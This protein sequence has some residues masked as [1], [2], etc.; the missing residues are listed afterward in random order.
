MRKLLITTA[1]VA[2]LL[3]MPGAAMADPVITPIFTAVGFSAATSVALAN[4]TGSILLS[5]AAQALQGRPSRP[6]LIRELQMPSSIPPHRFVYGRARVPGTW[7]PGWVVDGDIFYGCLIL[8]SRPSEGNATIFLDKREV[9]LTGD[10]YDLASDGAT[11]TNAPFA[12]HCR[13]WM[14][15]GDQ[16]GPPDK[17]IQGGDF[18][19][20]MGDPTGEDE[21]KFWPTDAWQG[22]T[23]LWVR[24]WAGDNKTRQSRWPRTPPQVEVL[25]D[26]SRVWDPRDAAQDP[27]DPDT[28]G[29]DNNQALCLLDALM[30]NP[31][32]RRRLKHVMRETWEHAADVADED[33]PLQAGGTEKRYTTNG[34][35]IWNGEREIEDQVSPLVAAGGGNLISAGGSLGYAS[36][37]YRAPIY[38]VSDVLSGQPFRFERLKPG[39]DLPRAIRAEYISPARDWQSAELQPYAVPGGEAPDG[40]D[41]G[42]ERLPL[43]TV[44]SATQ[45]MRLQ[46]MRAMKAGAQR[47]LTCELPPSAF[48]LLAGA[49]VHVYLPNGSDPRNG[50]YEITTL[51]PASWLESEDGVAM[52]IPVEMRENSEAIYAWES[53]EEQEIITPGFTPIDLQ[54]QPPQS[55]VATTGQ[56]GAFPDGRPG[57]QVDFTASPS[58]GIEDYAWHWRV[59]GGAWQMGGRLDADAD[60]RFRLEVD[61]DTDYDFR[62]RSIRGDQASAWVELADVTA[63]PPDLDLDPPHSGSAVGGDGQIDI[64]FMAPNSADFEGLQL[65]GAD[66]DDINQAAQLGDTALGAPNSTFHFTETGLGASQTRYY[67]ARSAGPYGATSA[68]SDSVTATTAP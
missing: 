18:L 56:G 39:R 17:L 22:R 6:Q 40:S 62:V 59:S 54:L 66:A 47:R 32:R 24:L 50:E 8:N 36:G 52:R 16:T 38:T 19:S 7:A 15:L 12:G 44:T 21:T 58:A 33:V 35:I 20:D 2:P 9:E 53:S 4:L 57:I 11:A 63:L 1:L 67:W 37:E 13:F 48:D 28:W 25:A 14:G 68:F 49:T 41:E 30:R 64:D 29:W 61:P 55:P 3:G 43:E 5:I 45:A 23:V 42:V 31:I 26:W 65:F 10:L 51:H 34:V 27:D 60:L 46:K